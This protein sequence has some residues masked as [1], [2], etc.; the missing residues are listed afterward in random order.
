MP[1]LIT[2]QGIDET[3][4][5]LELKEGTLGGTGRGYPVVFR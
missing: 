5:N 4:G 2:L 1:S 3:L